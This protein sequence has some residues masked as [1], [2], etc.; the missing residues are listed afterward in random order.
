MPDTVT[1]LEDGTRL[2]VSIDRC[3][4]DPQQPTTEDQQTGNHPDN[5][6]LNPTPNNRPTE[7][8][9]VILRHPPDP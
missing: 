6:P 9:E 1:I 2:K 4:K 8:N 7:N 5:I 3:V